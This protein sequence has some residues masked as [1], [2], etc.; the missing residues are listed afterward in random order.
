[1]DVL[2]KVA[3][4]VQNNYKYEINLFFFSNKNIFVRKQNQMNR[5][6]QNSFFNKMTS[7]PNKKHK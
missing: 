6:F 3:C 7:L 1:M 4:K 5:T 2:G